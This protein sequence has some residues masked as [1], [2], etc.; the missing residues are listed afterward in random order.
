M[1]RPRT[2][3]DTLKLSGDASHLKRAQSYSPETI[4]A[5]PGAPPLPDNLTLE[6]TAEWKKVVDILSE[7]NALTSGDGAILELYAQVKVRHRFESARLDEEGVIVELTQIRCG[8]PVRITTTNP[9]FKVV[10]MLEKQLMEILLVLGLTPRS[11]KSIARQ[12]RQS[13]RV[14]YLVQGPNVSRNYEQDEERKMARCDELREACI[15]NM[16]LVEECELEILSALGFDLDKIGRW[17]LFFLV[18]DGIKQDAEISGHFAALPDREKSIY[19]PHEN[20]H[21]DVFEI[22]ELLKTWTPEQRKALHDRIQTL[23]S[24]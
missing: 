10:R 1:G 8:Q 12:S 21:G 6:E 18:E 9:R 7:R 4:E 20:I 19:W 14:R 22:R 16:P 2:D 17:D 5:I 11:R 23:A 3:L 15:R 24:R 13:Q